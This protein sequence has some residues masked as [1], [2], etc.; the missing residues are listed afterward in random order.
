MTIKQL[1][2]GIV[3][4][5]EEE[6]ETILEEREAAKAAEEEGQEVA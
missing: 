4:A 3:Q 2:E 1:N 5:L 6:L